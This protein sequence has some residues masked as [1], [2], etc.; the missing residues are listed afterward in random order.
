MILGDTCTRRCAFCAVK[1]GRPSSPD[2]EE[3]HRVAEAAALLGLEHVVVTS[4]TRD[5][6]PDGGAAMFASTVDAIRRRL[7]H[8]TVEVLVP[9]FSGSGEAIEKVISAKP[10]V[11]N[12]NVETVPRLYPEVRPGAN[13][14][15]SINLIND[16]AK[17][18]LVTKSGMMLGM[19]EESVEVSAALEELKEAGCKILTL[20]QYLA[21][22]REH[23]PVARYVEPPEFDR[24]R[25]SGLEMGFD[26]VY[27]APLVRSSYHA[28]PPAR[29]LA[30][31]TSK[32]Y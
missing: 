8:A 3:P 30:P 16:V 2:S 14:N 27:A 7:P 13:W 17:S 19:G 10:D 11:F 21:P 6:L 1:K 20:G 15:Q 25:K 4:V 32:G 29:Q 24:W 5:D 22:T 9:D 12:H 18:G 26:E 23:R 31:L 28:K